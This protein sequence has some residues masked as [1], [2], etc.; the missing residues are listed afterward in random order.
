MLRRELG[1]EVDMQEGRYGE[2][3]VLV[4]DRPVLHGG[5]LT[6]IGVVP[7]LRQVR[8]VLERALQSDSVDESG[9]RRTDNT[10]Q[11]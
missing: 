3:T 11:G 5:A 1:V 9:N 10:G 6:F 2:F 7:S 8:D 4:D